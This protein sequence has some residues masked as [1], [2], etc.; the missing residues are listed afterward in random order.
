MWHILTHLDDW[1]IFYV[2]DCSLLQRDLEFIIVNVNL[3][4]STSI[5]WCSEFYALISRSR[6]A[7]FIVCGLM[8]VKLFQLQQLIS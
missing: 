8:D 4:Y 3:D 6:S 1:E 7:E 2:L 5:S